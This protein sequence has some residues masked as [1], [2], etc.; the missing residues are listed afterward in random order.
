[1]AGS[2]RLWS[3]VAIL[4]F[5][6]A[7]AGWLLRAS[8]LYDVNHAAAQADVVGTGLE[9]LRGAL[10]EMGAAERAFAVTGREAQ[11]KALA[12]AVADVDRALGTVSTLASDLPPEAP[13]E[14]LRMLVGESLSGSRETV[15][16]RKS[17]GVDAAMRRSVSDEDQVLDDRIRQTIREIAASARLQAERAQSAAGRTSAIASALALL[18]GIAALASV[19][20]GLSSAG[21]TSR[22]DP[23]RVPLRD[24]SAGD[25]SMLAPI[26][27]TLDDAVLAI[28]A[29]GKVVASN[30]AADALLGLGEVGSGSRAPAL[31][32][33]DAGKKGPPAE[34]PL[35]RALKGQSIKGATLSV[36]RPNEPGSRRVSV[37]AKP[38][39]DG[40]GRT[41]G[42]V[43]TLRDITDAKPGPAPIRKTET[44]RP[45]EPARPPEE[46]F[47]RVFEEAPVAVALV[48]V[49]GRLVRANGALCRLLGYL[50]QEL[51]GRD[52]A[53]LVHAD[54]LKKEAPLFRQLV[55]GEVPSYETE[56]RF[57][58]KGKEK[59]KEAHLLVRWS[60]C[61]VRGASGEITGALAFVD[62]A[63][64]RKPEGRSARESHDML[65]LVLDA[66][67]VGV[68]VTDKEGRV[69]LANPAARRIWS[70]DEAVARFEQG[71]Y[72]GF[73]ADSG[74]RIEPDEWGALRAISTGEAQV[75]KAIQVQRF[76]GTRKTLLTSAV[77]V[78]AGDGT[79]SGAIVVQ[80]E[81]PEPAPAAEDS[82]HPA[83]E[84][85][86]ARV[87][88]EALSAIVPICPACEKK[89][90]DTAYWKQVRTYVREH[91]AELREATCRE[92][93][94]RAYDLWGELIDEKTAAGE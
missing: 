35:L 5:G 82:K 59:G 14:S 51:V 66:V 55:L 15:R 32:A 72:K 71:E 54:D 31:Y 37:T 48:G 22:H 27:G 28:D 81:L 25:A 13:V 90:D 79:T 19:L 11:V 61:A 84:P 92:C 86:A 73:W 46:A 64:D 39:T 50:P 20:L 30:P 18:G 77:P 9:R 44:S 63:K 49:D 69:K 56:K 3:A 70:K 1:M 41:R 74:K 62:E 34:S 47:T 58:I 33:P 53:S 4:S 38:V 26:L 83:E 7:V 17:E 2:R 67:P 75:D 94:S 60:A 76:D 80:Q 24:E 68:W 21:R 10:S 43:M 45:P 89:R 93:S 52:P 85:E 16:L 29:H 36:G 87:Q 23:Y 8:A 12:A 42:A 6:L 57:A 40:E 78:R 65:R 91:R 88:V